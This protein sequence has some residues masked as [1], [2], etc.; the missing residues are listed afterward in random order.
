MAWLRR[1]GLDA[2]GAWTAHLSRRCAEGA[3]ACGLEVLGP[4]EPERRGPTTA[5]AVANA[6]AVETALVERRI[7]ASA[8]GPAIRLAPHFYNTVDDVDRALDA[9][10]ALAGAGA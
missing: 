3:R 10:A 2:I 9:V 1:I 7:L 5:I 6:H 4:A 8:R